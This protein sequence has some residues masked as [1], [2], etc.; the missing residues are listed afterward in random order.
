MEE[1]LMKFLQPYG[2]ESNGIQLYNNEQQKNLINN[3]KEYKE[4]KELSNNLIPDYRQ[5]D[6]LFLLNEQN[7]KKNIN[8]IV[9][10]NINNYNNNN[11]NNNINNNFN[12]LLIPTNS[13]NFNFNEPT[14]SF[15]NNQNISKFNTEL[16]LQNSFMPSLNLFNIPSFHSLKLENNPSNQKI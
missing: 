6:I 1:N 4:Y 9:N 8:D 15:I 16:N 14:K 3:N 7:S 10:N 2:E 12:N 11:I 5:S 13:S